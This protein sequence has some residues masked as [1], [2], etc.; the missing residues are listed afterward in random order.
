VTLV[1][2]AALGVIFRGARIL[3]AMLLALIPF[4]SVFIML[5]LARQLTQQPE[6]H[7]IGPPLTWASLLF[8]FLADLVILRVGVKR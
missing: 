8:V 4:F 1:M 7:L 2:G 3:A 6:T 5:V